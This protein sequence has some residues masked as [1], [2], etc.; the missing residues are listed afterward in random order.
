MIDLLYHCVM[1]QYVQH[2]QFTSHSYF[3]KE[4]R[5]Q[6]SNINHKYTE[7]INHPNFF[8]H[9]LKTKRCQLKAV[10]LNIL[11]GFIQLTYVCLNKWTS[12]F[13]GWISGVFSPVDPF[14]ESPSILDGVFLKSQSESQTYKLCKSS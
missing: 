13:T 11:S 6:N 8:F 1:H 5:N 7:Q 2:K 12:L 14:R 9:P 10:K 3:K 4:T